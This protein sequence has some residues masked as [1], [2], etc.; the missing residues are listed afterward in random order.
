MVAFA[1]IATPHV[2]LLF[3]IE[4]L[5]LDSIGDQQAVPPGDYF[6]T[7]VTCS[8]LKAGERTWG[9]RLLP[10]FKDLNKKMAF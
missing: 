6:F 8:F 4:D 10:V 7:V 1:T 3:R 9:R 2:T 5:G